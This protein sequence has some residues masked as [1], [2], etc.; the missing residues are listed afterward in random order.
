MTQR[1]ATLKV[2]QTH[3]KTTKTGFGLDIYTLAQEVSKLVYNDNLGLPLASL[4]RVIQ[5]LRQLGYNVINS[6]G[7]YRLA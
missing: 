5:E 6:R 3:R 7:A 2:L 4:R 1:E